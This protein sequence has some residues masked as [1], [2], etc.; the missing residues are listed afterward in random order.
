VIS[1][2]I[3]V[4]FDP[5]D[6]GVAYA[7]ALDKWALCCSEKY[8]IFHGRSEREIMLATTLLRQKTKLH[9]R[10]Q[11]ITTAKLATFLQSI[12]AQEALLRQQLSDRAARSA[13]DALQ[14][15]PRLVEAGYEIPADHAGTAL[16]APVEAQA[17][18][19]N[20]SEAPMQRFAVQTYGDF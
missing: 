10:Q 19:E 17:R 9:G 16:A 11:R 18:G 6:A 13:W 8:A 20:S 15:Y 5:W 7:Y 2:N 14:G 3:P 1:E 12:E 4:R